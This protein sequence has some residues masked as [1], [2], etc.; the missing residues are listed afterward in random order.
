MIDCAQIR[1]E[2]LRH[3]VR[4]NH[5]QDNLPHAPQP[6][7]PAR[8]STRPPVVFSECGPISA[9]FHNPTRV[10]L[11][12]LTVSFLFSFAYTVIP[13]KLQTHNY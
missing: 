13:D 12:Q 11:F 2:L 10:A 4:Q 1:L 6:Q 9:A 5:H 7:Q 3:H 8:T